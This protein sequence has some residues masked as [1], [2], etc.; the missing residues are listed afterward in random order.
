VSATDTDTHTGKDNENDNYN[1]NDNDKW[2]TAKGGYSE[3][4]PIQK[5]VLALQ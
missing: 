4:A 3:G 5:S 2:Q 1:S